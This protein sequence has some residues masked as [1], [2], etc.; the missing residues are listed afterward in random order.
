[1]ARIVRSQLAK[2]DIVDALRFTLERWGVA[3]AKVYR[4]LILDALKSIAADPGCGSPRF[5]VRPGVRGFHIKRSGAPAR[6]RRAPIPRLPRRKPARRAAA[7]AA[8]V[9]MITFG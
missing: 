3:Q 8:T 5:T 2:R 4:Q 1:M 7:L 9:G 6:P